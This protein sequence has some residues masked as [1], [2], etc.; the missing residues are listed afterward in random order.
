MTKYFV[1]LSLTFLGYVA[2]L[3]VCL[4]LFFSEG[5]RGYVAKLLVFLFLTIR[6]EGDTW[7]NHLSFYSY[8]SMITKLYI[9]FHT[10]N[11]DYSCVEFTLW[12]RLLQVIC[13]HFSS[14]ANLKKE[15]NVKKGWKYVKLKI[16]KIR[17]NI[18]SVW[19][20][21][22]FYIPWTYSYQKDR[23]MFDDP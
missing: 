10:C 7:L 17:H 2:K 14:I 12:D 11:T 5:G 23:Q 3:L 8:I 19:L 15:T 6:G 18:W 4:F 20:S 9:S 13:L 22:C 1:F 21:L 16:G